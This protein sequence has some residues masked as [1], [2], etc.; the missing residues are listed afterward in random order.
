MKP[1][2]ET[3]KE[4]GIAFSFP[5]IIEDANGNLTY[6]EDS[7]GYWCRLERDA[8]GNWTYSEDS[9]GYWCRL[10]RDANGKETYHEDSD[11]FWYRCE[12]D[13]DGNETYYENSNGVKRGTSKSSK[14][15]EGKVV[16]VDGIKYKL[17][18]L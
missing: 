14:T 10:E 4:L 13:A 5:I 11:D 12:R 17:T 1:L 18:A 9:N 2:S 6:R 15:C 3:Y 8:N 16:E 7:K